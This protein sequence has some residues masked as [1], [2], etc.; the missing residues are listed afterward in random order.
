[1][2]G[3][4][5]RMKTEES[6]SMKAELK[7]FSLNRRKKKEIKIFLK[8]LGFYRKTTIRSNICV[9]DFQKKRRTKQ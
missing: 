7:L 8:K 9:T 1:M 2:D 6:G 4:N 5:S 3:L